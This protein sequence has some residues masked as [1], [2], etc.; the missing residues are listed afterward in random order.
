MAQSIQPSSLPKLPIIPIRDGVVFPGT[1]VVLTFGRQR[2]VA[3][4]EAAAGFN[5]QVVLVMQKNPDV[6]VKL[7]SYR[8]SSKYLLLIYLLTALRRL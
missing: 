7:L 2:P 3:A 1:E 6:Y 5:K 8:G 4:I